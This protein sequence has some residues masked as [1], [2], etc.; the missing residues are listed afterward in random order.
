MKRSFLIFFVDEEQEGE[1]ALHQCGDCKLIFNNFKR[2]ITHK[3][4]KECWAA[5]NEES[6]NG[7]P[8][9]TEWRPD[10]NGST[11][12]PENSPTAGEIS[13]SEEVDEQVRLL[14]L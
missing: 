2:Y 3:V 4:Q 6:N 11:S 12:S 14:G 8:D 10:Q 1:R 5:E 13:N 9:D 7:T